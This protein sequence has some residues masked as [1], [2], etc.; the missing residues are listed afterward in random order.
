LLRGGEMWVACSVTIALA[1]IGKAGGSA[2]AARA[3]GMSW[4]ESAMIGALLN[5]RGLTELVVL[6]I[7]LDLG[8]IAPRMFSIMILMSI[9]TTLMTAPLL[10]WIA[11][12]ATAP[13]AARDLGGMEAVV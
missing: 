9:V 1:V 10:R 8:V 6:N 3:A 13:E 2:L 12:E 5:T 11:P 7:G 4:R